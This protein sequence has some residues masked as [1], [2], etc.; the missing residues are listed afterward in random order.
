MDAKTAKAL[1]QFKNLI[2]DAM[3]KEYLLSGAGLKMTR[4]KKET[5][6]GMV[7]RLFSRE[8]I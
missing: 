4:I 3:Y 8:N 5:K 7:R 6:P 1:E 2:V